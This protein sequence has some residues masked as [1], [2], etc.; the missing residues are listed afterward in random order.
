MTVTL[1]DALVEN[2]RAVLR[3]R[4]KRDTIAAALRQVVRQARLAEI[5]EHAGKLDL[6]FSHTDVLKRRRES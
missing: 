6:G 4:T 2:A 3:L 1:D 5:A